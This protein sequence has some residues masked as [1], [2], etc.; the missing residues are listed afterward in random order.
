MDYNLKTVHI[1]CLN[2]THFN[3]LAFNNTSL[4]IDT[5][6]HSMINVNGWNGTMIIYEN[7]TTLS[8]H[9]T[10]TSLGAKYIA[11]TFNTNIK[12]AIHI[13][14]IYRHYPCQCS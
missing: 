3:T 10:F 4:N 7:F 14:A 9:G 6:T 5:K 13:I 12:E 8:S 11:T 1:L 2:Q